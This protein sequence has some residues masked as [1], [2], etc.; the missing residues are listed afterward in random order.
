MSCIYLF[1]HGYDRYIAVQCAQHA[2]YTNIYILA[3]F[4]KRN[5]K[6]EKKVQKYVVLLSKPI[7]L[8][9]QN[10]SQFKNL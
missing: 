8:H 1:S 2:Y 6:L 5:G 9:Q 3:F 7:F 4:E 10:A